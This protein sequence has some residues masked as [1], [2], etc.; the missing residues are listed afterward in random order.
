MVE[1][2]GDVEPREGEP[3]SPERPPEGRVIELDSLRGLAALAVVIFHTNS[4]WLPFGWAAVDLFFVLSGCLITSIILRHGG[5]SGFLRTFY[6]RRGLRTWPIYYLLIA[7]LCII[8]PLLSRPCLWSS[9]PFTLTYTQGL[10]RVW[11]AAAEPFSRYLAHTWSLAIEEQFYLVWPALVLLAGRRRLVPLA[12]LCICGSVY[13]R[14]Q[15]VWWDLCSRCDGLLLGGLLAALQVHH[16]P[17]A[18]RLSTLIRLSAVGA[19]AFLCVLASRVGIH[20]DVLLP[21]Y[22]ASSVLAF[23]L[24]WLGV[25]DF[26]LEH[27]GKDSM[28]LLRLPPLARL[29]QMSYGLYLYH[30]PVLAILLDIAR[31]LGFLGKVY[32]LKVL[33]IVL[34][35]GLAKL[36]WRFIERPLLCMK[37]RFAYVAESATN[38]APAGAFCRRLAH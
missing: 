15:G 22:P 38:P 3:V 34:S 35:I 4:S 32:P 26:V 24:L 31:G 25:I 5:S 8:S 17:F 16:A 2:G 7:L 33:S 28:G 23:N 27:S 11:P 20:P 12:L 21:S 1:Q 9:L 10:A 37:D 29:G 13:A 36:S 18:R 14:S 6:V 30:F 19:L